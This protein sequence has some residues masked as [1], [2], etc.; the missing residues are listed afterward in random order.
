MSVDSAVFSL[1]INPGETEVEELRASPGHDN[2]LTIQH[3]CGAACW[4]A[5]SGQSLHQHV[6]EVFHSAERPVYLQY[7]GPGARSN[8][9]ALGIE[10]SCGL[11]QFAP[12]LYAGNTPH[13]PAEVQLVT[14]SLWLHLHSLF[15]VKPK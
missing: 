10:A 8:S 7:G 5:A 15:V 12:P 3:T 13:L 4:A 6:E 1:I 2:T 9:A 11:T 14:F